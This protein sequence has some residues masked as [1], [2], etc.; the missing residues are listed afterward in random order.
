MLLEQKLKIAKIEEGVLKD[1]RIPV[2]FSE[3][4]SVA[5]IL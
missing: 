2:H 1:I 4:K 5:Q 3:E